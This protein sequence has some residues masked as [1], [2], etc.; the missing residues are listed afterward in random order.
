MFD[1][2]REKPFL[3]KAGD[4]IKFIPSSKAIFS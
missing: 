2:N 1:K 4:K 3:V